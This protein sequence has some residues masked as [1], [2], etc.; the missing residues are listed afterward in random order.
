MDVTPPPYESKSNRIKPDPHKNHPINIKSLFCFYFTSSVRFVQM[1]AEYLA[2]D[3]MCGKLEHSSGSGFGENLFMC[4][5]S[6][7]TYECYT[8]AYA[9]E[10]LCELSKLQKKNKTAVHTNFKYLSPQPTRV[11]GL[12]FFL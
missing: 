6:D 12:G 1:H 3:D 7:M 2:S 11:L 5:S 4:S 9:M 10:N 8:P